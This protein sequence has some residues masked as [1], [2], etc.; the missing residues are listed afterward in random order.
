MKK[1]I[2]ATED[3]L[4]PTIF[5]IFGATGDLTKKKLIPALF[6]LY[7]EGYL[8][9]LFQ[10]IGFARQD[11]SHEEFRERAREAIRNSV[12]NARETD[13]RSFLQY[14]SYQRGDFQNAQGYEELA[15]VL[16]KK[17]GEWNTCSNKLFYLAVP[18]TYYEAISKHLAKSKLTE[19]CSPEEGWTRV[20]V[21]KPFGKDLKTARTLDTLLGT[22]FREEQIYRMDHYLG[23]ETTQNILAFRFSNSLIQSILNSRGIERVHVK[24]LEKEGIGSRGAFYD[25]VGALR[26]VGQN[27][28]LQ[29][30]ALFTMESPGR[31]DG[32]SVRKQRAKVFNKLHIP[33][34]SEVAKNTLRAQYKGYTKEKNVDS[35]SKTETYFHMKT[36]IDTKRWKGVP[37][38]LEGG[39]GL[40]R[41]MVEIAVVFRHST[42]CLC[43]PDNNKHY[44]NVLYYH[45]QP[46]E[47]IEISFWVKKPG[48]DMIL[49]QRKFSFD[50]KMAFKGQEFL[51]AYEKLL[52]D[53]IRGDQTLF[54]STDEIIASWKFIDAITSV[55]KKGDI[56]LRQYK[57]G[58]V[59]IRKVPLPIDDK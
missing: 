2:H 12:R 52:L 50:Y 48:P 43:P 56:P 35:N 55:W 33:T 40:E 5:V 57:K 54:V 34:A 10:V 4:L 14:F 37:I 22:L 9:S 46:N 11:I 25:G 21:E 27:H 16:G 17:D 44:E 7:R 38:Y 24:F 53:A 1:H 6:H 3:N 20:I 41:D 58:D 51:D 8:P 31:F 45:V 23:K 26:D 42:P 30:L 47:G 15:E 36:E 29:L 49:E 59:S 28:L 13:I 19:P 39:K 32:D 18:P